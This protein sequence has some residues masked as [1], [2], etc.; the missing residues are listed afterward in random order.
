MKSPLESAVSGGCLCGRVRY[1]LARAPTEGLWCHCRNCQ[2]AAGA[3]AVLWAETRQA[4]F[5]ITQGEIRFFQSSEWAKRG[6]CPQCGTPLVYHGNPDG[7]QDFGV[8]AATLDRPDSVAAAAHI[9]THSMRRGMVLDPHLPRHSAETPA[10]EAAREK[11]RTETEPSETE[12]SEM[13]PSET[14]PSE[15]KSS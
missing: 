8:A 13:E 10:F 5:K 9:W 11:A 7:V 15:T 3:P 2:R 6:F 12:P 1:A 14:E 4:D